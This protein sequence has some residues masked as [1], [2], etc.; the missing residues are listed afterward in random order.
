MSLSE[1]TLKAAVTVTA[2][3]HA[4]R[5]RHPADERGIVSLEVVIFAVMALLLAGGIALAITA[6]VNAR[7]PNIK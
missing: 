7:E 5:A 4:W 2:R 6:A 3:W 1:R